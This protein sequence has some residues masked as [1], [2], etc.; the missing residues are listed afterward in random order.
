MELSDL[1]VF[2][3]VV[4]AGGVTRAARQLHR[5]QS[6]VTTRLKKLEAELGV[7]LFYREGRRLRLSPAGDVL[8]D[9]ADRLLGLAEEAQDA[10]HDARPRGE[11][12]LGAMESTAAARLPGPLAAYHRRYPGVAI[13]LRTGPSRPMAAAVLAGELDA[14]LIAE[15]VADHR[16]AKLPVYRETLVVVTAPEHPSVRSPADLLNTTVLAFQPGCSY[17]SSLEAWLSRGGIIPS[18]VVELA[19][20]HA[21]LS[22]AAAGMGIALLPRSVLGACSAAIEVGVHGLSSEPEAAETVLVWRTGAMPPN[23]AALAELIGPPQA[24]VSA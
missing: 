6:N 15:P 10:L 22:G 23:V 13:R 9:Y 12:R 3:A 5:V 7:S 18:A 8:L 17:R 21:I 4:T 14:A 11:L 2:R 24:P 19:S 16:L 20:Y 1:R